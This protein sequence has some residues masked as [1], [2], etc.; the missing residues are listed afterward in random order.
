MTQEEQNILSQLNDAQ[1]QAVVYD[2]GP[3]LVVAGA[4]S[5]KT[6]VLTYKIAWLLEHEQLKPWSVLALTFTNKAANEMKS[7]IAQLVGEERAR[8]LQMGTFHSVFSHILRAEAQHIG[9]QSGFT[10][11]DET[12][13]RSLIKNIVKQME[14]DDRKYKPADV[15]KAIS[16]AKNDLCTAEQYGDD[17]SRIE[18]DRQKSMPEVYKIYLAYQQRLH[19]ANAMD[20][21]DL[22][23]LTYEL[24]QT[25]DDIRKKYASRFEY[26][27]VDEYQD[28][29]FVQQQILWQLTKERQRVCV[30]G[31]DYQSIYAFRGAKID[32]IL[33]F[34][35][36]YKNAKVFK[37]ER[38]YRSSR[39]IVAA[40]NS[41]MKHNQRQIEKNVYSENEE[42]DKLT[43][44]ETQSDKR[45]AAV[46]CREIKRIKAQEHCHWSDFAILYRTN[47]QSRLF[48]EQMHSPEMG[49]ANCYR[50]FGGVS[51]YQ[52]KEI[53]DALCYFRM[54]VN[55]N[56]D[57]ALRRIIN[58]PARGIG[59][60][61]VLKVR[62]V[63]MKLNVSMWD[64][65]CEPQRF[66]LE[67]NSGTARKL[68][69]FREMIQ[70]YIDLDTD[71]KDAFQVATMIYATSKILSS[72]YSDN[73]PEN[74]SRQ[75]NLSELLNAVQ[76]FVDEAKE[77][78][79]SGVSMTDFLSV[80]QLATDQDSGDDD[81]D[82]PRVTLMTV[83]AAKGLEFRN[84]IIV[85]VEDEMFPSM[86]SSNSLAEVEEER[87]LLYVAITRAQEHCLMTYATSRYINGQTHPCMP[88]RFL[89]DID[90]ALLEL[91][92]NPN[93]WAAPSQND[94][95]PRVRTRI[96]PRQQK[97]EG[98]VPVRKAVAE[99]AQ[100]SG[101][102]TDGLRVGARINHLR[103]GDGTVT[104]IEK[105]P[106][107]KITVDFDNT[108]I[109]VLL[110]KFAKF[111]IIG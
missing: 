13:S 106:D 41:L 66:G 62:A 28:T 52:R 86:H 36:R 87:R 92:R 68:N 109:K 83:H 77:E 97:P 16:R 8:Y 108:G 9:F 57:E 25:H 15:H 5:G 94:F 24:F 95:E 26:V 76:Q 58:Y 72:L 39:L 30:V 34:T 49:M 59:E 54:S 51:F 6:R 47:A 23:M 18:Q 50:V 17:G 53:K 42:G 14:L 4:G 81:D 55:P 91:P 48:E 63:A 64:V 35:S 90:S 3:E 37:L 20:F 84:V 10:I 12:D 96:V 88:S 98:F 107:V 29:N 65:I 7:R 27:L 82:S 46:V 105:E 2:D 1:R 78:R 101:G 44:L 40:A 60:K 99:A 80:V 61:T 45:E 33:N 102:D 70:A 104:K 31:D 19:Q 32:N 85:G 75:E 111:K 71:G 67:V 38:N 79:E 74:I 11:Y 69:G 100:S 93:T 56:D 22:L 110:L 21:D 89:K 103:F 43:V 73:T